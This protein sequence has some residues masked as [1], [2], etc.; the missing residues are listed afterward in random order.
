VQRQ[1]AVF[2]FCFLERAKG[3]EPST[4]TLGKDDAGYVISMS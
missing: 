1:L 3:L 4:F 2:V